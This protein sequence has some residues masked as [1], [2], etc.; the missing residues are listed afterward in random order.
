MPTHFYP[1]AEQSNSIPPS[2]RFNSPSCM[3]HLPMQSKAQINLS[4]GHETRSVH[5]SDI[6]CHP[7]PLGA[8]CIAHF[9]ALYLQELV[10][11]SSAVPRSQHQVKVGFD[12]QNLYFYFLLSF[13]ISDICTLH[14]LY[15]CIC[16]IAKIKSKKPIEM[17][18][19]SI[20]F[21]IVYSITP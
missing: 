16:S 9:G 15:P 13:E 5:V 18:N 11:T 7:I 21:W 8:A 4:T 17:N 2:A 1:N 19:H 3:K 12:Y 14:V 10:S 6:L 20:L